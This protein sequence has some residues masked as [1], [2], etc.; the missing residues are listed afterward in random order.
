MC[1]YECANVLVL[2]RTRQLSYESLSYLDHDLSTR[3]RR[4]DVMISGLC[5]ST[6]MVIKASR[7]CR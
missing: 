6:C 3:R 4:V 2:Y 1:A 5:D 7:A